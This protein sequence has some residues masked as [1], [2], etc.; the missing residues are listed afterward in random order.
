MYISYFKS[1]PLSKLIRFVYLSMFSKNAEK[2]KM[3]KVLLKSV[4]YAC[5][6]ALAMSADD[7]VGDFASVAMK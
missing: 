3:K 4:S 7:A 5:I 2:V 6:Y 1:A